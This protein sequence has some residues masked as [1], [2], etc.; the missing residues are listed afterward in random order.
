MSLEIF[1]SLAGLEYPVVWT[2][3]AGRTLI[4]TS[5]S[6]KE[7][8]AALWT[9]PRRQYQLSFNFL[10]DNAS[11]EF[12]A[13]VAFVLA[14]QGAYDSFLFDDP[15]DNAVT[16]QSL[17]E[18]AAGQ[19]AFQ[20]IRSFGGY[21]EPILAPNAV[22]AVYVNGVTVGSAFSV[23]AQGGTVTLFSA[24][25]AGALITADFTYYWPC[26]FLADQYDFSKFMNRLWE[27]KKLDFI[28]LKNWP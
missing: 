18:A 22:S 5:V 27:Q 26:R 13:L 21:V 15:D 10:R 23:N 3:V 9:Y 12:R 8:R 20:L 16:G 2:P 7:N 1:P 6:G 24:P 25:P 28:T 17:G 19:T 4:Q 14:R 11:D